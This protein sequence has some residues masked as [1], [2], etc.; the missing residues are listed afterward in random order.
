MSLKYVEK[1][2]N[3]L[4]NEFKMF[5]SLKGEQERWDVESEY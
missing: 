3:K 5:T 4:L 1:K 2:Q